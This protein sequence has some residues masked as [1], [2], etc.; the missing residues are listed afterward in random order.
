MATAGFALGLAFGVVPLIAV[1]AYVQVVSHHGW[2]TAPL[3]LAVAYGV[4]VIV[5]ASRGSKSAAAASSLG[6]VGG[7][8]ALVL[9]VLI[10][11]GAAVLFTHLIADLVRYVFQSTKCAITH[12]G[13]SGKH[14]TQPRR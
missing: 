13:G 12:G 7:L 5:V 3:G 4:V 10:A 1:L 11:Y 14:C 9:G 6:V 2:A 8:V